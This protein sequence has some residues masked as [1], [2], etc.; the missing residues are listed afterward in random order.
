[1]DARN[2]NFEEGSAIDP[3]T[4]LAPARTPEEEQR[5]ID[6]RRAQAR[7]AA[8][9]TA[10]T[11]NAPGGYSSQ[12]GAADRDVQFSENPQAVI[13][14][15][16]YS[17]PGPDGLRVTP[18]QY[19]AAKQMKKLNHDAMNGAGYKALTYGILAAP[20]LVTGGAALAGG[21]EALGFGAGSGSIAA[22]D[23]GTAAA[24]SAAASAEPIVQVANEA[25]GL[26]QAGP[27]FSQAAAN[28]FNAAP[29][30]GAAA[31]A[32][33]AAPGAAPSWL[34]EGGKLGGKLLGAA[35]PFLIQAALGGKTK[36]EKALIAK[37]TQ[38]AQEAK[39][40]QGQQQDAR[41]NQLGQQLLAFNPSNQ[42]MAQ[43][44]GPQAAF[45]P[46]QMAAMAQG[47]APAQDPSIRNYMG[48]DQK[49]LQAKREMIRRQDEYDAA[50]AARRDMLM[51]GIQQPG[52]GPT[53]IQMSAPQ[54][55]RKY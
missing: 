4:G 20:S 13:D 44:Y 12:R 11:N 39:V 28:A 36:E 7:A 22:A 26:A 3:F 1:V 14:A 18:E 50:E 45:Q 24:E 42:L 17:R 19:A 35:A 53:P 46:E 6:A 51:G 9:S 33:A 55:A 21:P 8:T 34:A 49:K 15:Y 32:S 23:A 31:A 48:D 2:A 37:Q 38:L 43:M 40:R 16:V 29:A 5:L 30:T 27:G 10:N 41:M 47:Q 54:A 52:P 25:T